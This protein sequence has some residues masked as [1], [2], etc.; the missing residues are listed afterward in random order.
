LKAVSAS[1]FWKKLTVIATDPARLRQAFVLYGAMN[2]KDWRTIT[3]HDIEVDPSDA[4]RQ[5]FP[6]LVQR[7]LTKSREQNAFLERMLA[8]LREALSSLLPLTSNER[9]FLDALWGEGRIRLGLLDL[10]PE[11]ADRLVSHHALEWRAQQ[12][13]R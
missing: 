9:E 10:G 1:S 3:P 12:C 2:R 7:E 6:L 11:Q 4:R 13:R 5:L 8:E